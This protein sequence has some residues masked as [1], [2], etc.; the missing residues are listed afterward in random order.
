MD[1]QIMIFIS[2]KSKPIH[3]LQIKENH[4]LGFIYFR[5]SFYI[6]DASGT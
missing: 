2:F 4:N 3:I 5:D 1:Q 6:F